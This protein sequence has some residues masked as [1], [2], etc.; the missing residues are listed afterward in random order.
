MESVLLIVCRNE[1]EKDFFL[2]KIGFL[3]ASEIYQPSFIHQLGASRH[4]HNGVT[5][6]N[7]TVYV[8]DH[9]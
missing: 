7:C 5:L 1:K 4:G 6:I 9:A 3:K 8:A 2:M